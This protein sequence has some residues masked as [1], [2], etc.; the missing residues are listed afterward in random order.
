MVRQWETKNRL[1]NFC[2]DGPESTGH[3]PGPG[4]GGKVTQRSIKG[5]RL[6]L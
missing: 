1:D 3:L 5:G 6:M 2:R 4:K